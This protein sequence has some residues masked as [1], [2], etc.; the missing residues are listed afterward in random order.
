MKKITRIFYI[1]FLRSACVT[2][3]AIWT[4]HPVLNISIFIFFFL[5]KNLE[6]LQDSRWKSQPY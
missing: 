4:F 5:P 1:H 3:S 6:I 2:S